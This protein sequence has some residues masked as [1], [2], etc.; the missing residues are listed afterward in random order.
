MRQFEDAAF[1]A[2]KAVRLTNTQFWTQATLVSALGHL[3]RS[4]ETQR[5]AADLYRVKPDFSLT[6]VADLLPFADSKHQE[7]F[8]NGLRNAGL[9]E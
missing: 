8:L 1:W 7:L 2:R 4:E 3:G 9:G 6:L 5:T